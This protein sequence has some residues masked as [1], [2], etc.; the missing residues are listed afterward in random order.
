MSKETY[1]RVR[2][3]GTLSCASDLHLSDGD[4]TPFMERPDNKD[5]DRVKGG[6]NTVCRGAAQMPY[7]P[8]SSLRGAVLDG[9]DKQ[10][11]D[12]RR[13]FGYS[14]ANEG[15]DTSGMGKRRASRVRFRDAHLD[16]DATINALDQPQD[17][18]YWSAQRMT[19]VRHGIA[20]DP[21]T[22]SVREGA[23]FRYELVPAG[24]LFSWTVELDRPDEQE[25]AWLLG[26]LQRLDGSP[27]RAIGRGRSLG[28]GRVNW[29]CTDIAVLKRGQY[30]QWLATDGKNA[31]AYDDLANS[32]WPEPLYTEAP[33]ALSLSLQVRS[34]TPLLV[35]EP[36]LVS[37]VKK[38]PKLEFSRTIDG[39]ALV[40]GSS[41]KGLVRAHCA[42]ILATIAHQHYGIPA[43][44]AVSGVKPLVEELF[45]SERSRALLWFEDLISEEPARKH[46][47]FFNAVDRF[48]GGV[49]ESDLFSVIA[50]DCDKLS[51][52]CFLDS[53]RLP[54][55]DWW[56]G[57]LILVIRDAMEGQLAVG[58]GK[59]KGY[60]VLH[61]CTVGNQDWAELLRDLEQRG[62]KPEQW[63]AALHQELNQYFL[64]A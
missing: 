16:R 42:R 30:L 14:S 62:N 10:C 25:L 54:A 4:E 1:L 11:D 9:M 5:K 50:A 35:N 49:S 56:K 45:G 32:D 15:E 3:C 64:A 40:P 19:Y 7:L 28:L 18:P 58:W 60:G 51:S 44:Q 26:L 2:I 57:L 52:Q 34:L 61:L 47:Q 24:S 12:Y 29:Q 6:Y 33:A 20:M 23:L 17:L 55:N 37:R 36:G 22:G 63:I 43:A 59:A 46:Q 8:G 39:R 31:P 13:L 41:F 21:A 53:A 48:T 27:W 38:E